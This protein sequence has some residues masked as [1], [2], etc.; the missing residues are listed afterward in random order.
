MAQEC[1]LIAIDGDIKKKMTL[2]FQTW[3]LIDFDT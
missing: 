1:T 3:Y 2:N